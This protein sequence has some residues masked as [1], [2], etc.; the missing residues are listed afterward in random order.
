MDNISSMWNA[1]LILEICFQSA[2]H[3][4]LCVRLLCH[5]GLASTGSSIANARLLLGPAEPL[6]QD[7][8]RSSKAKTLMLRVSS[9]RKPFSRSAEST[10]C[11]LPLHWC[12]SL[13]SPQNTMTR[14][15]IS[16]TKEP[17]SARDGLD[18]EFGIR[19]WI[20][21]DLIQRGAESKAET[22]LNRTPYSFRAFKRAFQ[23]ETTIVLSREISSVILLIAGC[24][25]TILSWK[26]APRLAVE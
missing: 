21:R 5:A 18:L 26:G 8:T 11:W 23:I 13:L 16:K 10:N 25:L 24:I 1:S 3:A 20:Q 14:T 15:V 6:V 4:F 19:V 9:T 17:T 22:I 7:F 12:R 2:P